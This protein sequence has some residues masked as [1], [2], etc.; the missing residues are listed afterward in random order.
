[1]W[2]QIE[3]EGP[4][5]VE[6]E[7]CHRYSVGFFNLPVQA[8]TQGD[9]VYVYSKESYPIYHAVWFNKQPK[10]DILKL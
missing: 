1:M 3:E 8:P 4:F 10:D 2:R 7:P 6:I 9:P 5:I